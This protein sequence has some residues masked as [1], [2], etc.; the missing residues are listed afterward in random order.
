MLGCH[1][2]L[3]FLSCSIDTYLFLYCLFFVLFVFL[4]LC[5]FFVFTFFLLFCCFFF[6]SRRRHTMCA[7]VTGVQTCALPISMRALSGRAERLL[8]ACLAA[9]ACCLRADAILHSGSLPAHEPPAHLSSDWRA[10]V[11][12]CAPTVSMQPVARVLS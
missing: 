4:I 3:L 12:A 7:L 2:S 10:G 5:S 8:F 6:S 1:Y 11:P 9:A